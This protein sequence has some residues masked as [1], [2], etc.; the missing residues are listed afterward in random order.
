M[1]AE[2]GRKSAYS[3]DVRLHVVHQRIGMG[4]TF[5]TIAQIAT[6]II[7]RIFKQFKLTG[8]VGS[9]RKCR[10]ELNVLD[11][12]TELMVIGLILE[13]PMLYLQEIRQAIKDLTYTSV[14]QA[15]IRRLLH[16]HGIT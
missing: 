16:W 5:Q 12:Q 3:T 10:P 8:D 7:H 14:S 15:T 13:S 4:L 1:S 9:P 6:S 2:P 11:E